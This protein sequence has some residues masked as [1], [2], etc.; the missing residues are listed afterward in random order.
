MAFDV[1]VFVIV[2]NILCVIKTEVL[3]IFEG[4]AI[5]FFCQLVVIEGVIVLIWIV[6]VVFNL[7]CILI[8]VLLA[9]SQLILAVELI[10]VIESH[11]YFLYHR[12]L[13]GKDS[14]GP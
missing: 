10:V 3:R 4:G 7:W 14:L 5:A 12:F 13:L 11:A 8:L 2:G 6:V 1:L 9:V